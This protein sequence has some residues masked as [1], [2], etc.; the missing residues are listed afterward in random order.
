VEEAVLLAQ[1]V[2]EGERDIDFTGRN[3]DKFCAERRLSRASPRA[4]VPGR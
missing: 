4:V 1:P 3:V 2:A